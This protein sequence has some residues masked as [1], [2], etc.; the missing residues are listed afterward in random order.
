MD[1]LKT[2]QLSLEHSITLPVIRNVEK[3]EKGTCLTL[4]M[5][6]RNKEHEVEPLR[7]PVA[8]RRRTKSS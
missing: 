2:K 8:K 4:I 6:K 3:L 7:D 5:T 1:D